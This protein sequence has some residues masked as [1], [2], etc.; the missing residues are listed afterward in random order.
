MRANL[1]IVDANGATLID[2]NLTNYNDIYSNAVDNFDAWKMI[3]PGINFG[4][5]RENYNLVVERRKVVP[6]TDTTYFR[7]WNMMQSNYRIRFVLKNLNHT[8]LVAMIKD[9]YLN[10]EMNVGLND[11]TFYDFTIDANN[12]SAN[13]MR[14]QLIYKP[15]SIITLDVNFTGIQA[16]RSGKDI[17]VDWAVANEVSMENYIVEHS[18]DGRNFLPVHAVSAINTSANKVYSYKDP[19][20]IGGDHFYRIKG[21][22][23]SGKIQY[24][25]IAKVKTTIQSDGVTVYPNPV[26]N[27]NVQIQFSNQPA[28]KYNIVLLHNNGINQQLVSIVLAESQITKSV[29]L[30]QNIMPGVY[31]LQFAGPGESKFV[32]TIQ[33]L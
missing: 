5:M 26:V 12:A 15:I 7:M 11:T 27:K 18:T 3:N 4:I 19:V 28:G 22:S 2:G 32:K 16:Q 29:S 14:F 8:G 23:L 25:S 13:E 6:T 21:N 10:T 17:L 33:V 30:P 9:N 20:T 1:Y 31:R 24:S